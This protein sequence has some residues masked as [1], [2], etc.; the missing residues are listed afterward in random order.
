VKPN[1]NLLK[2][3]FMGEIYAFKSNKLNPFMSVDFN[4]C[5]TQH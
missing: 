2:R 3:W 4:E 5:E 1:L